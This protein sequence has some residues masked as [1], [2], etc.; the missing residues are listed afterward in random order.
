MYVGLNQCME[1]DIGGGF[2]SCDKHEGGNLDLEGGEAQYNV[3]TGGQ[4][5]KW[6]DMATPNGN[7]ETSVQTLNLLDFLKP[8]AIGQLPPVIDYIQGGAI[9]NVNAAIKQAQCYVNQVALTCGAT[10][11]LMCTYNWRSLGKPLPVNIAAAQAKQGNSLVARHTGSAQFDVAGA[12]LSGY[13]VETW[14]ATAVNEITAWSS[15]DAAAADEQRLP[16][17]MD[18]GNFLVSLS[19]RV[20][21][22]LGVNLALDYPAQVEFLWSGKDNEAVAKTFSLDLTGG[23][24][25]DLNRAPFE[26]MRGAD[27][28]LWG[29][30]ATA[31]PND[32][33][34]WVTTFV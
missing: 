1:A 22:P 9:G 7:A 19:A 34:G 17:V 13:K 26:I 27:K 8:A 18:P 29:I 33:A 5:G 2:I 28:V 3:G 20:R 12:G 6:R 24:G 30:E 31:E 25:L 16:D 23:N 4:V 14:T 15:Q 11:V 21:T 10:G 32:L